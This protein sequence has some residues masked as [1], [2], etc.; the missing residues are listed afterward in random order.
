MVKLRKPNRRRLEHQRQIMLKHQKRTLRI[1]GGKW[2]GRKI[3]FTEHSALRPTGDRIRET[4]FNWLMND[5]NGAHCLDLFS[6]SGILAIEAL[7]RGA[8]HVTIIEKDT[9]VCREIGEQLNQLDADRSQYTLINTDARTWLTQATV[10]EENRF[11]GIFVDPPFA[12]GPL[13]SLCEQ[14]ATSQWGTQWVY[15]ESGAPLDNIVMPS[16][17]RLHRNKRAGETHYGLCHCHDED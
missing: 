16:Q 8:S 3:T 1:I 11:D 17:W 14:L 10:D 13:D 4:L 15:L 12:D 6:G 2:R 7:S 5:I 9:A